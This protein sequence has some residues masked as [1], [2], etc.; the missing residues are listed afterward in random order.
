MLGLSMDTMDDMGEDRQIEIDGVP[1]IAEADV[2]ERYGTSFTVTL[3]EQ[4]RPVV[5]ARTA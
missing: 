3:D 4:G 2:L 1:F 5:E